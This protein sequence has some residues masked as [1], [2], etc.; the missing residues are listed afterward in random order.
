MR[1]PWA[2]RR[3]NRIR[4]PCPRSTRKSLTWCQFCMERLILGTEPGC[5]L[6]MSLGGGEE[7]GASINTGEPH[8]PKRPTLI[9]ATLLSNLT[10]LSGPQFP[11]SQC[12]VHSQSKD[13]K[14]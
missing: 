4:R 8:R 9:L 1:G 13:A 5:S 12:H 14:E 7:T 2:P 11:L 10:A 3:S 6:F